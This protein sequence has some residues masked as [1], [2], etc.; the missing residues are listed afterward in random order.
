MQ[1]GVQ[2]G[3]GNSSVCPFQ[4]PPGIL[5]WTL[6]TAT[7]LTAAEGLRTQAPLQPLPSMLLP[8]LLTLLLL[9]LLPWLVPGVLPWL[10]LEAL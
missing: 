3:G 5:A 8:K 7:G 4:A 6:Q 2:E 1:E 10:A 9:L